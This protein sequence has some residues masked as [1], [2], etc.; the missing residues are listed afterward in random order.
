MKTNINSFFS[1]FL[2]LILF[3]CAP[4]TSYAGEV[5]G[6]GII[7]QSENDKIYGYY[8]YKDQVKMFFFKGGTS[9]LELVGV[10]KTDELSIHWRDAVG[11]YSL[12]RKTLELDKE[13]GYDQNCKVAGDYSK[14]LEMM[15]PKLYTG[16]NKI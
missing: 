16:E 1:N 15:D 11:S 3:L 7:C 12:N 4:I 9:E 10:Y 8:F 14:F 5:D 6:K 13:Y 2:L